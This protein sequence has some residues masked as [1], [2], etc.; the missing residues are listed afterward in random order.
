MDTLDVHDEAR[1]QQHDLLAD[2]PSEARHA[3]KRVRQLVRQHPLAAAGIATGVGYVLATGLPRVRRL[4]V[5]GALGYGIYRM[6]R[7]RAARA[8][9]P[10]SGDGRDGGDTRDADE[11]EDGAPGRAAT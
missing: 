3:A 7:R 8:T 10:S 11:R 5:G 2:A 9:D 6:L 4:V 1:D